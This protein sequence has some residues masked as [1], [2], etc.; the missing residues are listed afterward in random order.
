MS[1][2]PDSPSE[3]ATAAYLAASP[4]SPWHLRLVI[5]ILIA[6]AILILL[7]FIMGHAGLWDMGRI[8]LKRDLFKLLAIGLLFATAYL[9][10][11]RNRWAFIP[12]LLHLLQRCVAIVDVETF[13]WLYLSSSEHASASFWFSLIIGFMLPGLLALSYTIYCLHQRKRILKQS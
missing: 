11:R 4:S 8:S 10:H 13:H 12:A 7:I 2:T 9:L 1:L 5:R 3:T 6:H